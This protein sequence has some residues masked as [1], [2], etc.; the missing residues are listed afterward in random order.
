MVFLEVEDVDDYWSAAAGPQPARHLPHREAR[1]GQSFDWGKECFV[2]D[3]SGVLWHM[4]EFAP[5]GVT[6]PPDPLSGERG[7]RLCS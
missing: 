7:H 5:Y 4:G 1:A 3:P 6:S 2:H